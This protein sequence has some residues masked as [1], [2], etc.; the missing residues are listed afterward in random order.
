MPIVGSMMLAQWSPAGQAAGM[1]VRS[2]YWRQLPSPMASVS[3]QPEPGAQSAEGL[4]AASGGVVPAGRHEMS[5]GLKYGMLI[6]HEK[7]A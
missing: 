3:T 1:A 4:H 7:P 5:D 6:W 2:Q